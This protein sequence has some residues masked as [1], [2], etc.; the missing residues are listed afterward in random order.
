MSSAWTTP[1]DIIKQVRKL[2]D[3]GAILSAK[4]DTIPI[5]PLRL[6]FRCPTSS[7]L[8]LQFDMAR[9][10]IQVLE[11]GSRTTTGFGYDIVWRET[12]L[13]QLGRNSVPSAV[14]ISTEDDAVRLLG[15]TEE[16]EVFGRVVEMTL[17]VLPELKNWLAKKPLTALGHAKDW[18][19]ILKVLLWF[20]SHPH[21]GLYL[22]QLD[23]AGVDTKFIEQR[24]SVL[25]E[26]LDIVLLSQSAAS[27]PNS[28]DFEQRF[29]L[30]I[31]PATIRFRLLAPTPLFSGLLDI[32]T[33]IEQ[34]STTPLSVKRI[35][36]TEN[37]VNGL[38]FPSIND[39]MVFFG[40]GYGLDRL[41]E[42]EWL[43]DKDIYYW[44]DIDT[45]GFAILNRL[46]GAFPK[47][48][49]FL[50]DQETLMLHRSLWVQEQKQFNGRLEHLTDSE[51]SLYEDLRNDRFGSCVRLEQERVAFSRVEKQI[52]LALDHRPAAD[53]LN[54]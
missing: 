4:L 49:S 41:R 47:T 24:R 30:R 52:Q 53:E 45:H 27:R 10:W 21:S 23:I 42:I 19:Q 1:E 51:Q 40:L 3:S 17:A 25:S 46:R 38:A 36:I 54:L 20:R 7:D 48:Q 39:A 16:L 9:Q 13:R 18:E 33:P 43:H 31:K 34:L 14:N 15:K 50:M 29:G 8:A 32:S 22:R 6:R 44:G 26:L 2:W 37:E 35:F 28:R 12:N 11:T 5:F